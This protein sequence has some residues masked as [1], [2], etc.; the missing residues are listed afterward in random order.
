M[1]V[2]L[3]LP[4]QEGGWPPCHAGFPEGQDRPAAQGDANEMLRLHECAVR[5]TEMPPF[6][7][8]T[9]KNPHAEQHAVHTSRN[10]GRAHPSTRSCPC[11]PRAA[12]LGT[13]R[14]PPASLFAPPPVPPSPSQRLIPRSWAED[15]ASGAL[16]GP[17]PLSVGGCRIATLRSTCL[18]PARVTPAA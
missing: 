4:P 13:E 17:G 1:G 7:S 3:E 9:G 11:S 6:A 16:T 5:H 10:P 15:S 14:L 8:Q 2:G 12:R 18:S